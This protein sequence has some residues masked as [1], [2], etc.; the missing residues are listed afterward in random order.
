[1]FDFWVFHESERCERVGH[2]R[3][4]ISDKALQRIA[5][6]TLRARDNV[7]RREE[8]V[9]YCQ[10]CI[11][12]LSSSRWESATSLQL[13]N[14]RAKKSVARLPSLCVGMTRVTHKRALHNIFSFRDS[15]SFSPFLSFSFF[16]FHPNN[17][18]PEDQKAYLIS[19]YT[20][21][22]RLRA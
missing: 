1:M 11:T 19:A 14:H 4:R 2:G 15:L 17:S 6:V 21:I 8:Q 10:A 3:V 7:A 13:I 22:C 20:Y 18:L 9:F 16:S 12:A 5:R